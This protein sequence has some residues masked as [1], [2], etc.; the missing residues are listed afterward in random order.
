MYWAALRQQYFPSCLQQSYPLGDIFLQ[1]SA[2]WDY[3]KGFNW[4][5]WDQTCAPGNLLHHIDLYIT[6]YILGIIAYIV[7]VLTRSYDDIRCMLMFFQIQDEPTQILFRSQNLPTYLKMPRPHKNSVMQHAAAFLSMTR[8]SVVQYVVW[9]FI[10]I[11]WSTWS[12]WKGCIMS[13]WKALL[14][15]GG[16]SNRPLLSQTSACLVR[17]CDLHLF[18]LRHSKTNQWFC[19]LRQHSSWNAQQ[20]AMSHNFNAVLQLFLAVFWPT[21]SVSS[22]EALSIKACM[23]NKSSFSELNSGIARCDSSP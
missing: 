14:F 22:L 20:P 12:S 6:V 13:L 9:Q 7:H 16:S 11:S 1:S 21:C 3:W 4:L 5:L 15:S 19:L 18:K 8:L 10:F 2:N 23:S 17:I